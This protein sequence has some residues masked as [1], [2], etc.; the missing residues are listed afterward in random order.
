MT[1]KRFVLKDNLVELV[2]ENESY[3]IMRYDPKKVRI[4]GKMVGL[5]RIIR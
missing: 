5:I 3:P 4:I 1:L 2:P